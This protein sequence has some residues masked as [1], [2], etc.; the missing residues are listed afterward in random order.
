M[1]FLDENQLRVFSPFFAWFLLLLFIS[2]FQTCNGGRCDKRDEQTESGEN[3][4]RNKVLSGKIQATSQP[5]L[6]DKRA[7]GTNGAALELS[8]NIT[9]ITL[10]QNVNYFKVCFTA[11]QLSSHF[12]FPLRSLIVK[13]LLPV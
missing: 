4:S 13:I 10:A 7:P 12:V 9:P 11:G 3:Y 2:H 1:F 6:I 8:T 5:T